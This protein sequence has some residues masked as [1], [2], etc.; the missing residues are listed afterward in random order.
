MTGNAWDSVPSVAI[1]CRTSSM[2]ALFYYYHCYYQWVKRGFWL[3]IRRENPQHPRSPYRGQ[4]TR[5]G[6]GSGRPAARSTGLL[7]QSASA[8]RSTV[9]D[10]R[11]APLSH[12]DTAIW[13]TPNARPTAAWL[14][15]CE[16]TR[17]TNSEWASMTLKLGYSSRESV[18]T[19][20]IKFLT[21]C[22]T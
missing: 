5:S 17:A 6:A 1:H 3:E 21:F 4:L 14:A 16:R 15:R 20:G 2:S 10:G 9:F 12:R 7:I 13:L 8:S 18:T 11:R 22:L 19:L